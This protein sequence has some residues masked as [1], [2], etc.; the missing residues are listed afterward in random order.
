VRELAAHIHLGVDL[1]EVTIKATLADAF[2]VALRRSGRKVVRQ[3]AA[4]FN[5]EEVTVE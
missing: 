4:P 2:E 1:S 5:R 3:D